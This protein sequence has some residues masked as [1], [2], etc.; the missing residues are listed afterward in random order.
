MKMIYYQAQLEHGQFDNPEMLGPWRIQLLSTFSLNWNLVT[1]TQISPDAA[2]NCKI[3]CHSTS[4]VSL[5]EWNTSSFMPTFVQAFF[6]SAYLGHNFQG[7]SST[8][9]TL[10]H[11]DSFISLVIEVL[12]ENCLQSLKRMYRSSLAVIDCPPSGNSL[13]EALPASR[14]PIPVLYPLLVFSC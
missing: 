12:P 5:L 14:S 7:P 11:T 4:L 8:E 3:I 9:P 6:V 10:Y 1:I 2:V 13:A